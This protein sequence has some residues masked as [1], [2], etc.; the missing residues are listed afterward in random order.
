[1][2]PPPSP[3]RTAPSPPGPAGRGALHAA[4]A[5]GAA[6]LGVA[7]LGAAAALLTAPSEARAQARGADPSAVVLSYGRFGEDDQPHS[8]IR[9]DQFE[10]HL[11]ALTAGDRTVLPLPRIVEA[12]RTGAR[13]PDR[14]VA[15]TIDEASRSAYREAV[16]RLRAA[17]LPFTVFVSPEPLDRASPAHMT[18]DELREVVAAGATVGAMPASPVPVTRR[19]AEENEAAIRRAAARIRA[20]LGVQPALFAY[21]YGEHSL[22]E[23]D[24]V[25]RLGFA[26]AFGQQSGAAHAGADRFALPR[27][28]M[29]E[30]LGGPDRFETAV[31]VLPLPAADVAPADPV[32]AQNPPAFG[33]TV[34]GPV[35]DLSRLACFAS[36]IGRTS[37]ERVGEDR[38]EVRLDRPFPPGRARINC[39]LPAEDGRWRWFGVQFFVPEPG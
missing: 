3:R 28:V 26:A 5:L 11:E 8:S 31:D 38:I 27:F 15:I 33:F 37:L 23:R 29:N 36:G 25:E 19:T 14:A 17:G 30:A 1:M 20:E 13:L 10:A 2:R 39:T 18:W 22:A 12:L 21:P 16:P 34:A 32:L 35:G 9:L 4:A 24:L 6:A 7:A